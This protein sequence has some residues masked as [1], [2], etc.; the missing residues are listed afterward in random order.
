[1]AQT[2]VDI[3]A[4]VELQKEF[5][6]LSIVLLGRLGERGRKHLRDEVPMVTGN[7]KQGVS[8]PEIDK[9]KKT[10][11]LTVTARSARRGPRSATLHLKSGKTKK[12]RLRATKAKNYAET[13]ARGYDEQINPKKAKALII[14]YWKPGVPDDESYIESEGKIFVVRKFTKGIKANPYDERAAKKLSTESV[15]IAAAA[16]DEIFK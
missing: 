14:P 16:A 5:D 8:A 10:A 1:M 2:D 9:R 6:E 12:I 15:S 11:T 13:V 3:S 7:L 4:L